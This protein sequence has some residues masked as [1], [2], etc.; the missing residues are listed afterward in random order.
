MVRVI[1]VQLKLARRRGDLNKREELLE[2]LDREIRYTNR[3]DSA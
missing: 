3:L 1:Y 2:L